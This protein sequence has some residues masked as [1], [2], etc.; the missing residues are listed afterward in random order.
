MKNMFGKSYDGNF[1][2]GRGIRFPAKRPILQIRFLDIY[3][4]ISKK[5]NIWAKKIKIP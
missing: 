3:D 4:T 2:G 5:L 1:R